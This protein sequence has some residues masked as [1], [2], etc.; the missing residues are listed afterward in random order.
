M[1]PSVPFSSPNKPAIL[2]PKILI[3]LIIAL[4]VFIGALAYY[5]SF[6]KTIP[7]QKQIEQLDPKNS[8]SLV[9]LTEQHN[10]AIA[11]VGQEIIYQ[12]DLDTELIFQPPSTEPNLKTRMLEKIASDS[13]ILQGAREIAL[14]QLDESVFNSKNKDYAKRV[15]L[16]KVAKDKIEKE[17]NSIEG[18]V[19]SVWFLN[20]NV[21]QLGYEKAKQL[22]FEK[23]SKLH[24]E[25]SSGKMTLAQ[26]SESI[27]NDSELSKIDPAY[28]INASFNFQS[29]K[30]EPVT[31]DKDFN[32]AIFNLNEGE[33]TD[34]LIGVSTDQAGKPIES[35][36]HFAQV[37]KKTINEKISSFEDWLE[38]KRKTYAITYY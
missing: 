18:T 25:V 26:A 9:T 19:I 17:A 6:Q 22:T 7:L 24:A 12:S 11:K 31:R 4:I 16:V 33:I 28:K 21:G 32:Q 35:H 27:K 1:E 13:A 36:Y 23:I 38:A 20:G 14:V 10:K 34:L 29:S 2:N 37:T 8:T 5:L 30:E 15:K 3:P